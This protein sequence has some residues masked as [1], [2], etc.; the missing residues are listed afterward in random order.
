MKILALSDRIVEANHSPQLHERHGDV[1]LVIGC[2]DLPYY[3][4]EY[5]TTMLAVPV[6]YVHGNHDTPTL[7]DDGCTISAPG[8]CTSLEE[9]AVSIK[10]PDSASPLLLAGLGGSMSYNQQSL[11]QYS[12]NEMRSRALALLPQL[13][14]NRARY[15]RYLDILVTH[16]PPFGIHDAEDLPHVGFKIFLTL[17]RAF[18]PRYLLHGHTHIY[19]QSTVSTTDYAQTRVI[20]VYPSRVIEWEDE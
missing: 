14:A 16:A 6:V 3:Y 2:G 18:K 4:L 11:H 9:R 7:T 20:N 1:D 8:G 17:L 15:G 10:R 13:M 5:I 19:R 12:E